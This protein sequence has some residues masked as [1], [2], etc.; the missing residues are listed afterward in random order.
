MKL[1]WQGR[2]LCQ[3]RGMTAYLTMVVFLTIC[4]GYKTSNMSLL[5]FFYVPTEHRKCIVIILCVEIVKLHFLLY[6]PAMLPLREERSANFPLNLLHSH[7]WPAQFKHYSVMFTL[8]RKL[9]QCWSCFFVHEM[10]IC[11]LWSVRLNNGWRGKLIFLTATN[12][13]MFE[14]ENNMCI[15]QQKWGPFLT[16]SKKQRVCFY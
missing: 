3:D 13:V 12:N 14:W 16:P 15:F 5:L 11:W 4:F 10:L 2:P 8:Q 9:S 6:S 7:G 1:R